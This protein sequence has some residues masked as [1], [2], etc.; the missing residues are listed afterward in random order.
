LVDL[1]TPLKNGAVGRLLSLLQEYALEKV[2]LYLTVFLG[3]SFLIFSLTVY[4]VVVITSSV[5]NERGVE[6]SKLA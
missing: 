6:L 2:E 4:V 1:A 5:S 3:D